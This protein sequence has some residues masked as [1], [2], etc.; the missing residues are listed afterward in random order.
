MCARPPPSTHRTRCSRRGRASPRTWARRR[1]RCSS[2]PRPTAT[3]SWASTTPPARAAARRPSHCTR[4]A[5]RCV[6]GALRR[7]HTW[8]A[9]CP[10]SLALNQSVPR[11]PPHTRALHAVLRSPRWRAGAGGLGGRRAAAPARGFGGALGGGRGSADA[12]I[13]RSARRSTGRRI[14]LFSVEGGVRGCGAWVCRPAWLMCIL[15]TVSVPGAAFS[16]QRGRRVREHMLQGRERTQTARVPRLCRAEEKT[17]HSGSI[18]TS[19]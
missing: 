18:A 15:C 17:S 13:V 7:A 12:R 8:R 9:C 2:A 11:R 1:R 16:V 6:A 4:R 10:F 14:V 3:R 5:T 19:S